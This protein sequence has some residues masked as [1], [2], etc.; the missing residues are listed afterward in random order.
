MTSKEKET[1]PA[2]SQVMIFR[3]ERGSLGRVI[4]GDEL[5]E[6]KAIAEYEAGGDVVV[7]GDDHKANKRQAQ[8]IANAVGPNKRQVPH[9]KAGPYALPHYQADPRPPEGHVF[10]ETDNKK[11]AMNK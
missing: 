3:A 8:M 2:P 10:Y 7:C 1:A 11:A 5:V 9:K 4:R 6:E